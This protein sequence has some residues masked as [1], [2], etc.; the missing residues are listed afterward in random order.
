MIKIENISKTLIIVGSIIISILIITVLV[1]TFNKL[2]L[3][4]KEREDAEYI[5]Q[6][7]EWNKR[8]ESFNRTDLY[9]SDIISIANLM[10]DYNIKND[11]QYKEME[12]TV[13]IN[14][15]IENAEIFKTGSYSLSNI[16]QYT[17]KLEEQESKELYNFKIK[18]FS[19]VK[20]EYDGSR[21]YK[22]Q[23]KD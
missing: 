8:L 22:M 23:F 16:I 11:N 19:C 13:T 1:F 9:G 10:Q 18:K 2:T 21:I 14:N 5:L 12:M 7:V 20:I 15:E 17:K 3:A 4:E 6:N